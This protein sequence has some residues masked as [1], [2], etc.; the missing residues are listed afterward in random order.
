LFRSLVAG[1]HPHATFFQ[2]FADFFLRVDVILEREHPGN[3]L[4]RELAMRAK[5]LGQSLD[6]LTEEMRR[7]EEPDHVLD[8]I[9]ACAGRKASERSYFKILGLPGEEFPPLARFED[10]KIFTIAQKS[11]QGWFKEDF[12]CNLYGRNA[13]R[14]KRYPV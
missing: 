12:L 6:F 5:F 13:I 2:N 14:T 1:F 4:R 7:A 8:S 3:H 9:P 10:A 11:S